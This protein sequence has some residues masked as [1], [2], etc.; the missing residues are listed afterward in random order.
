MVTDQQFPQLFVLFG[1]V[2]RTPRHGATNNMEL[3]ALLLLAPGPSIVHFIPARAIL[4][5]ILH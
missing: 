5:I 1:A 3:L 4:D 2:T